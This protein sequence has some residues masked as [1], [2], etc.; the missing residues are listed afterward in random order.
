MDLG[1]VLSSALYLI[2]RTHWVISPPVL[3]FLICLIHGITNV[4]GYQVCMPST[5]SFFFWWEQPHFHYDTTPLRCSVKFFEWGVIAKPCC[6]VCISYGT[7]IC[8]KINK[9]QPKPIKADCGVSGKTTEMYEELSYCYTW[10]EEEDTW[11]ICVP[12]LTEPAWVKPQQK[13][14]VK[15]KVNE[16]RCPHLSHWIS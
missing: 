13:K 10:K 11:N 14:E 4:S 8:S 1:P 2:S 9:D 7:G 16:L 5:H 15:R 3:G 6:S 12:K